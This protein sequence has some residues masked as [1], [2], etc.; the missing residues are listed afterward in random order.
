MNNKT[1]SSFEYVCVLVL[2]G[3]TYELRE[4][5][6]KCNNKTTKAL[7]DLLID[8]SQLPSGEKKLFG[9]D[10]SNI[11]ALVSKKITKK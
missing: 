5:F 9:D 8:I 11:L 10:I 1:D 3:N 7:G 6:N 2:D 4:F